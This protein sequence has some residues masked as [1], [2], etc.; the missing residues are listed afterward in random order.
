[1]MDRESRYAR[2]YSKRHH[3][4]MTVEE[5]MGGYGKGKRQAVHD[6]YKA[7][8]WP[9]SVVRTVERYENGKKVDIAPKQSQVA[10]LH[11][12]LSRLGDRSKAYW[13]MMRLA[14]D[15]ERR[16]DQLRKWK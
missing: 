11:R 4:K 3:C 12:R 9:S 8:W 16:C 7:C 13:A 15:L 1:M 6:G 2:S 10:Q 14:M 5:V